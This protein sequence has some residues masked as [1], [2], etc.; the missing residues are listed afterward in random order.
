[1]TS[2]IAPEVVAALRTLIRATMPHMVPAAGGIVTFRQH[3][4]VAGALWD[5]H[6][7]RDLTLE[8]ITAQLRAYA[9][10]EGYVCDGVPEGTVTAFR[11]ENDLTP[12]GVGEPDLVESPPGDDVEAHMMQV[13]VAMDGYPAE[14]GSAGE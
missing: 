8:Q 5:D 13:V 14:D 11:W 10:Q 2:Q 4:Y 1:M 3:A 6:S 7:S 9:A 12:E